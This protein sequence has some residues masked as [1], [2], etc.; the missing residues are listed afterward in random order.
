MKARESKSNWRR[1]LMAPVLVGLALSLTACP[2]PKTNKNSGIGTYNPGCPGCTGPAGTGTVLAAAIGLRSDP[3]QTIELG[4]RIHAPS[5]SYQ[6]WSYYGPVTATGYVNVTSANWGGCTVMPLGYYQ[7]QSLAANGS[8][9]PDTLYQAWNLINFDFDAVHTS[10]FR[11]RFR[12]N[13]A[14]FYDQSVVIGAD[15]GQFPHRMYGELILTPLTAAPSCYFSP[16]KLFFPR[17]F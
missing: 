2:G 10:G 1:W 17:P 16:I 12:V 8:Y 7:I 11:V 13:Y 15:G 4:L 9:A 5:S 6:A 3:N 14:E